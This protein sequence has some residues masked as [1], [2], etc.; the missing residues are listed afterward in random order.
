LLHLVG[1]LTGQPLRDWKLAGSE[2]RRY[3]RYQPRSRHVS[4]CG[5]STPN[6]VESPCPGSTTVSSSYFSKIPCET[7]LIREAKRSGSFQVL[8]MHTS[9]NVLP[10]KIIMGTSALGSYA[11][12]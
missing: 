10:E 7:S 11:T 6:T 2:R 4:T 9:K 3:S 8:T 5:R 12:V 1:A